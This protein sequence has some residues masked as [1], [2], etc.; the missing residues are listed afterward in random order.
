M[1]DEEIFQIFRKHILEYKGE[2]ARHPYGWMT[3]LLDAQ[4]EIIAEAV[5][6]GSIGFMEW[7]GRE[8][9]EQMIEDGGKVYWYQKPIYFTQHAVSW[10]ETKELYKMYL[11]SPK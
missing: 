11:K 2:F 4:K 7:V 1:T 9:Y 3:A 5:E 6:K 8:G 10:I